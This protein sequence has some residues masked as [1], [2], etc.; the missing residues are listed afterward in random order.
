MVHLQHSTSTQQSFLSEPSSGWGVVT[1]IQPVTWV[2][3]R[4]RLGLYTH[5]AVRPVTWAGQNKAVLAD[6]CRAGGRQEKFL[7][8]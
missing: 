1:S 2:Q 3:L 8:A 4:R 7:H 6:L 5:D